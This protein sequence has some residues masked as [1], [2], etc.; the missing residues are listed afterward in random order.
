MPAEI[1]TKTRQRDFATIV[2]ASLVFFALNVDFLLYGDA[3]LYGDY[4][5]RQKI[6]EVTLHFGYY[7]LLIVVQSTLGNLLHVP[8]QE[9]MVWVNVVAGALSMGIAYLLALELLGTRRDAWVTIAIFA[10]SGRVVG[11]ATTSEMYMVQTLCVLWSF[12]LFVRTR[13]IAAG[14]LAGAAL[15]VSPLSAFAYLFF[16]V[17][18]YQRARKIRIG[19]LAALTAA[20]AVVYVPYLVVYGHELLWGARGLLVIR[21]GT[22]SSLSS[23]LINFPKYQFKEFTFLLLLLA[24][25]C[26]AIRK[27]QKFF[28]LAAAVAIPHI[29]II[30]KLTGEDNV[31]ILNTDF[32]FSAILA[33][34]WMALASRKW[35]W[36]GGATL[37]AAHV[38][39]YIA[40]GALFSFETHKDYADEMRA[41]SRSYL[42]DPG[43][44][45]VTDWGTG[46][47]LTFFSRPQATTTILEEPF[48][49]QIYDMERPAVANPNLTSARELYLIDRWKPTPLNRFFRTKESI[50]EQYNI[51]SNKLIAERELHLSCTSLFEKTNKYYRCKLNPAVTSP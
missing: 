1:A 11:N 36:W 5:L 2:V 29:Y 22:K 18:D 19:T 17:F 34:G 30:L 7:W 38:G 35:G 16:P 46:T 4:A 45:V 13:I 39:V 28:A 41:F 40:S 20:A 25:A 37:L 12:L 44:M 48:F 32:F 21:E 14:I 8:M 10:F 23:T 47:A 42:A 9:T 26:L 24:P 50:R 33:L 31:F 15:L 6:T 51:H 49:H 27:N 43:N 3:S